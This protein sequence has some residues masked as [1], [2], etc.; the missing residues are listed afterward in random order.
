MFSLKNLL[1]CLTGAAIPVLCMLCYL[2]H[3]DQ[4]SHDRLLSSPQRTELHC[5][6]WMPLMAHH[7]I[8]GVSITC[9][10]ASRG[11]D[12]ALL[13]KNALY[14]SIFKESNQKMLFQSFLDSPELHWR[15]PE[16]NW[17]FTAMQ[18]R[19]TKLWWHSSFKK[20]NKWQKCNNLT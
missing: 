3:P 14:L 7:I 6:R 15:A 18:V 2:S 11:H 20:K 8:A 5:Q 19:C 16:I 17:A 12:S 9:T 10:I 4:G 1:V 13:N